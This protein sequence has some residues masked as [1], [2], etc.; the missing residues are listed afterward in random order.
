M[1]A[2]TIRNT[3]T[4]NNAGFPPAPP[5]AH[6]RADVGP[7]GS[8][9]LF[10]REANGVYA[11]ASQEEILASARAGVDTRLVRGMRAT[12]PA[13][14]IEFLCAKLAGLEREV[15]SVLFLD[16][17]HALIDYA[18]LFPGTL[19][20]TS[21]YPREVVKA[22]LMRNAAAVILSHN[23][24]SGN[25]QPSESDKTLTA[26]LRGALQLIDI[27]IVDHIVVAGNRTFSFAENGLC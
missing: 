15:F 13:A 11:V 9:V 14:V 20:S 17:Q 8:P 3:D 18:D 22:A 16:A 27:C 5:E 6:Q 19:T 25:P 4:T 12:S 26:V 2:T 24:P 21:V 7:L 1:I 23:H 10:V